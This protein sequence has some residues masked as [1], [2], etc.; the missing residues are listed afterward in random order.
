MGKVKMKVRIGSDPYLY[1][2]IELGDGIVEITGE[3]L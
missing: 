2:M 3:R 1:R